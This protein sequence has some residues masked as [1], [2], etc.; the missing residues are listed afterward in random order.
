MQ[1]VILIT[2]ASSGFGRICAEWFLRAG[3]QVFGTSRDLANLDLASRDLA[4]R[5]RASADVA[6]RIRWI[7]L[8]VR[9]EASVQAAV[10]Q[11]LDQA[12]HIDVLFNNAGFAMLGAIEE[13]TAEEA[14]N[15]FDTNV[16]GLLAITRA[17]LPSMRARQQGTIVMMS[18][19]SGLMGVPY[20]GVYAASKHAVEAIAQALRLEVEP[21]G[22][23]V[24]VIEPEAHRTGIQMVQPSQPVSVYDKPRQLVGDSIEQQIRTGPDPQN[25]ARI[26][27]GMATSAQPP[28]RRLAGKKALLIGLLRRFVSDAGLHW[29]S[30][31][32]FGLSQP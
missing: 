14:R 20:H 15:L 4:Q 1:K 2:G 5:D 13:T 11:V 9:V 18:S 7:E 6:D 3:W 21:F 27:Y 10:R 23:R 22:I 24:G 25:I 32:S 30:R 8:D 31:K 17:V 12:G 28:Y 26:L 19:I 29:I 16:L